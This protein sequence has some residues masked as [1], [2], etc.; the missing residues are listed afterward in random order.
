MNENNLL[1][2]VIFSAVLLS[3]TIF[4]VGGNLSE[5]VSGISIIAS[6]TEKTN[7]KD[8]GNSDTVNLG[9]SDSGNTKQANTNTGNSGSTIKLSDLLDT[10]AGIEGNENAKVIVIEYSDYQCP[11]CRSW[12]NSSKPLIDDYVKQGKVLFAYKD[13]PLNNIHPMAK[14]YAEAARCAGDQGKYF[15]FHDKIYSEQNALGTGTVSSITK[16]DV[17]QWAVNLGLNSTEFNSC[18][19]SGKYSDAVESNL[20]EGGKFG[21][22]GT[23]SF[24]IGL[25]DGEGQLIRGAQPAA[26]FKSVI[27]ALLS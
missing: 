3:A 20:L 26:T 1:L 24:L 6:D 25:A 7:N 5:S 14:P 13:F 10:A 23:P 2:A 16:D 22:Q 27:D 4:V 15:E 17:K 21:V 12:F 19:D 9:D 18:F 11:F 8:S